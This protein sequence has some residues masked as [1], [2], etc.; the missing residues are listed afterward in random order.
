MKV[1]KIIQ[2][3][4]LVLLLGSAAYLVSLCLNMQNVINDS[5]LTLHALHTKYNNL[6]QQTSLIGI[7]LF[8]ILLLV[9]F[10]NFYLNKNAK[11]IVLA[12]LLYIPITLYSYISLNFNF[13]EKQGLIPAENSGYW[14]I[15]FIGIFYIIGAI[16]VSVIGY[17]TIRN[18]NKRAK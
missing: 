12:N 9:G 15:V 4:F 7:V 8:A 13:Y 6:Q 5:T 2:I 14:L 3:S 11:Y 17:F 10:V 1:N 18:L 16:L